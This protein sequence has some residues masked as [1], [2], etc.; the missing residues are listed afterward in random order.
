MF[1]LSERAQS[2]RNH[3]INN[4]LNNNYTGGNTNNNVTNTN[5]I[6]KDYEEVMPENWMNIP[7]KTHIVYQKTSGQRMPGM[8]LIGKSREKNLLFL[9]SDLYDKSSFSTTIG[10]DKIEKIWKKSGDVNPSY[11]LSNSLSNHQQ[12]DSS[13]AVTNKSLSNVLRNFDNRLN[14]LEQQSIDYSFDKGETMTEVKADI[15]ALKND[16][17]EFKS[18]FKKLIEF[19][20]QIANT[21][22]KLQ[23]HN[24]SIFED[25]DD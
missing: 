11:Q 24:K 2:S 13:L 9:Q 22:N 8:F 25:E 18:D 3:P 19:T 12:R 4:S 6:L 1:N 15:I 21:V 14:D 7:E 10:I 23:D 16:I 17:N 20:E 5:D